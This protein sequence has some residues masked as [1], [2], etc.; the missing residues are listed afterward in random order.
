V[1]ENTWKAEVAISQSIKHE[2]S[3]STFSA[4]GEPDQSAN[5]IDSVLESIIE[6]CKKNHINDVK[7]ILITRS[8][9]QL[10]GMV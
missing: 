8:C 3:S 2:I 6:W 9:R 10:G 5:S 1:F 7:S 4:L